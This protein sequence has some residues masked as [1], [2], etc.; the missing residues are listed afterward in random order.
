MIP[1]VLRDINNEVV[2]ILDQAYKIG[3]SLNRNKLAFCSFTLPLNDSKVALVQPKYFVELHDYDRRIGTFIVNPKFTVKNESTNEVTFECEHVLALLHN[4][5]LLGYHQYTN[6]NTSQV[7]TNLLAM[8]EVKHWTLGTVEFSRGFHYSW[9]NEDSLLNA[10]FSVPKPFDE[11]FTWS[12]NDSEYPFTLN[13]VKPSDAV[14]GMITAGKDLRG[15]EVTSDPTNIITRIYPLGNGEGVNQLNIAKVNGGSLY[16]RNAAA[17]AAYGVHKR[18]W[19]DRRFEDA[20]TLKQSAQAILDKFSR[21]QV[22]VEIEALDYSL[23]DPYELAGYQ[24]GDVLRVYDQDTDTDTLIRLEKIEKDDVYGNPLDMKLELGDIRNTS[25]MTIA[26]LQKK[27]LVN[28]TYSQGATNI[29]SR[30]FSDNCDATF[31]AELR[32]YIPDDVVNI[33]EMLLTFETRKYRAYSKAIEGGGG[34]ATS[35]ASGGG[36]TVT[37]AGGGGTTKSTTSGG[38]TTATSSSGGGTTQSTTSGGVHRHLMFDWI[39]Q[40]GTASLPVNGYIAAS[41]LGGEGAF[42]LV[43]I[44]SEAGDLYTA[45]ASDAHSHSVTVPSHTH[46]VTIP[47]HSHDVTLADHSHNVSIPNHTHSIT[48]PNHTHG[49]QYGIY[50]FATLPTSVQITVDGTVIPHTAI[51]G[52][53]IDLLP[54]LQKDADGNLTRGRYA[55]IKIKPNNLAHINATVTSRLFIQSRIGIKA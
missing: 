2:A 4:D 45:G 40:P 46:S 22:S 32:F 29:D 55:E 23:I 3:Y 19:V 31:P 10:L 20:Q 14:K 47:S 24:L 5:I 38:G 37:S 16:L 11:P 43:E 35:T 48:L 41:N 1:P 50:E 18:V 51:S 30:D 39:D 28:D 44:H 34:I 49:I 52:E 26:D 36:T 8:Q 33:N 6:L 12:Y 7:L 27:Q 13:L 42:R 25:A 53:N 17:E 9:E 21:P 15:I 54:Y